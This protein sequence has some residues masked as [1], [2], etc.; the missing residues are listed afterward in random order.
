MRHVDRLAV[1]MIDCSQQVRELGKG[2]GPMNIVF[3][4]VRIDEN[5]N[6]GIVSVYENESAAKNMAVMLN[7][8]TDNGGFYAVNFYT[9]WNS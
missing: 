4:V 8:N 2:K 1:G 9:V 5:N 3:I 6:S 7:A